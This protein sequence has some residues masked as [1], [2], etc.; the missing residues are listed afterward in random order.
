M[1]ESGNLDAAN[2]IVKASYW[3]LTSALVDISTSTPMES[4]F[5]ILRL[6][7]KSVDIWKHTGSSWAAWS[8]WA[9]RYNSAICWYL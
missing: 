1:F 9:R 5:H 6:I 7:L 3:R 2:Y 8:Y 4:I